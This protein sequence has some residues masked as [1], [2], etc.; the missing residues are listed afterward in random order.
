MRAGKCIAVIIPALNEA[1]SIGQVIAAIPRWVDEIIVA[2]NGST[3]G[4]A[5]VARQHGARVVP[6][7][8]R[9]YGAACL[10]GIAALPL[11]AETACEVVVFLDGDLSDHPEEMHRLVD[12]ILHGAAD[13]VAGSRTLG[14]CEAGALTQPQRFGNW[15]ACALI[16]LFW[17]RCYSDLGPFRAVR[18]ATLNVLQM[19]DTGYGW[20]VEMQIKATRAGWRVA[21]VPVKYRCRIGHSKISG[22]VKGVLGAGAKILW[23][24]F[25]YAWSAQ[26]ERQSAAAERLIIFTR[27]PE[28]GRAKTRLIP[29]LGAA[30]AAT[31]H[32]R[33]A[34][35]MLT[36][37]RQWAADRAVQ[38]EV[39]YDGGTATLLRN[40]LGA[41]LQ[42]CPQ[43]AGDFGARLTR[44]V[45]D[46][47]AAG[48]QRVAVIGA[49][50]PGLSAEL[51]ATAFENLRQHEL[52]LGPAHDGGYYLLGL[53]RACPSLF[54]DITW[55]TAAV[56]EQTQQR[57][58]AAGLEAKLLPP[59]GDV[60]RPEDLPLCAEL[61]QPEIS[62][63]LIAPPLL[64]GYLH[65]HSHAQ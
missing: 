50:C 36:R 49:D 63:Q 43:G 10:A 48:A 55:G 5:E 31:L 38:L 33:L 45:R 64:N 47:F 32:R 21:E 44:A 61:L 24:I 27:Y 28:A 7:A 35:G 40:W 15:L 65:H 54:T 57:A 56:L 62:A 19:S 25:R 14:A 1:R 39:R 4:T 22:T 41:G 53:R 58:R 52:V 60:D 30:G 46:A 12:P 3:D 42:Y 20:M 29:A 2:D 34:E 59:L 17:G 23:T 26:R 13:L 18:A 6:A 51:L 37:A 8:Q 16:G 11:D 9:G